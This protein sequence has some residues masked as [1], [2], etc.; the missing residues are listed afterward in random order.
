MVKVTQN[1][2]FPLLNPGYNHIPLKY[3]LFIEKIYS[4]DCS[5]KKV[6]GKDHKSNIFTRDLQGG[7]FIQIRKWFVEGK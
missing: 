3:Q 1:H 2:N 7:I 6:D 5:M 4:G